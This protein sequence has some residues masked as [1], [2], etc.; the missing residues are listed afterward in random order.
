M[1]ELE[2]ETGTNMLK[3]TDPVQDL[4]ELIERDPEQ[5]QAII[6]SLQAGMR[7]AQ[8]RRSVARRGRQAR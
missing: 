4:L 1:I 2:T 8:V 5:V 7:R 3:D 6:D